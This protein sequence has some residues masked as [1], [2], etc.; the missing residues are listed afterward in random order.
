MN[1]RALTLVLG[2]TLTVAAGGVSAVACSSSSTPATNGPDGSTSSSGGSGSSSGSSS[3]GADAGPDCGSTPQ[4]RPN[5]AGAIYC[6]F[7]E[8]GT[9]FSCPI[10][11]QCC[12]GGE[13]GS[14]T[15]F[16]P[17]ECSQYNAP[18]TNGGSLD[19]GPSFTPGLGVACEQI[20]DCT[21]NGNTGANACCLQGAKCAGGFTCGGPA[22]ACP[23][24]KYSGGTGIACEGDAGG[25]VGQCQ[26][27]ETQVCSTQADCPAGKTCTAGKWK[28]IQIGFC[29]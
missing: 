21:V 8:A 15:N 26:A 4:L 25:A 9:G 16:A 6:G 10:G 23:Y 3:G 1:I 13:L 18:C 28:I 20:S 27:G 14:F 19:A 12:L 29:L 5:E 7:S 17:D 2:T 24:P 22:A 11:E